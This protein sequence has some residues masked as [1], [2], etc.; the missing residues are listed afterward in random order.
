MI[1]GTQEEYRPEAGSTKDTPYLTITG[2]LW[3]VFWEY[4][5]ENWPHYNGI[6]LYDIVAMS[7]VTPTSVPQ[8]NRTAD[9]HLILFL[10]WHTRASLL[11]DWFSNWV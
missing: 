9:I 8:Q 11:I 3:G 6:A 5:L 4:F 10:Y 2:E 7:I 1:A